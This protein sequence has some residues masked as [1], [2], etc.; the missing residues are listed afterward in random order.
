[1][2][3][4]LHCHMSSRGLMGHP[5]FN[6]VSQINIQILRD[7]CA[8]AT[9]FQKLSPEDSLFFSEQE[10]TAAYYILH[11]EMKYTQDPLTSN[12]DVTEITYLREGQWLSEFALWCKWVHVGHAQSTRSLVCEVLVINAAECARVLV[13]DDVVATI[14]S[15]YATT[16]HARLAADSGLSDV[17]VPFAE[18]G[19]IVVS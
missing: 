17:N 7:V 15:H 9:S 1:M 3:L 6:L 4:E 11:G 10:A 12:V 5:V 19:K 16:F 2:R 18:F 14:L 8:R 13:A